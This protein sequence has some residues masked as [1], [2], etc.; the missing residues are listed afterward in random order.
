MNYSVVSIL[1]FLLIA[2][3]FIMLFYCISRIK[4][5]ERKFININYDDL[6]VLIE[7]LKDILIEAERVAE[8]LELEIKKKEDM[9]ADLSE[10]LELKLIRMEELVAG[11]IDEKNI[12]NT[13]QEMAEKNMDVVDIAKKLGISSAEVELMLKFN[14]E[15]V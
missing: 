5:I 8:K 11:S 3:I 4:I 10:I 6:Q 9:L 14:R 7:H 12:K 2:I 15:G 1:F 13:V